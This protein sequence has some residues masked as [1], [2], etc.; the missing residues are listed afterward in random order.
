MPRI[1]SMMNIYLEEEDDREPDVLPGVV[2]G[3]G[4]RGPRRDGDGDQ[5]QQAVHQEADAAWKDNP[6]CSMNPRQIEVQV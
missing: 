3:D 6:F 2:V 5:H 4:G 1:S